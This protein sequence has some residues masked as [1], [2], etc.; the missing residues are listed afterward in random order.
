MIP[1]AYDGDG[2]T[3]NDAASAIITLT[4]RGKLAR[5]QSNADA[6]SLLDNIEDCVSIFTCI[7]WHGLG[8]PTDELNLWN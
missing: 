4:A 7:R 2:T 6:Q 8:R 1:M 3:Q 5:N